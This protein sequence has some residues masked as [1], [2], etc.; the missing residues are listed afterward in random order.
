M[1]FVTVWE[2]RHGSLMALREILSVQ[3]ASAG[4][5]APIPDSKS[6]LANLPLHVSEEPKFDG[7]SLML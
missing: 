5:I 7:L 2:V 3:A 4:V 6:E 1:M